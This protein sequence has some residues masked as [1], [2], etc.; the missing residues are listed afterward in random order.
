MSTWMDGSIRTWRIDSQPGTPEEIE[1]WAELVTGMYLDS[2]NVP[3]FLDA[4]SRKPRVKAIESSSL[5]TNLFTDL[6]GTWGQSTL[7]NRSK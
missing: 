6:K 3:N 7:L 4:V 1:N 5:R 2:Q